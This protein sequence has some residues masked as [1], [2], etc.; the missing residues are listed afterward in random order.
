[1]NRLH[2]TL[3]ILHHFDSVIF[4]R[5]K[6]CKKYSQ[7]NMKDCVTKKMLERMNQDISIEEINSDIISEEISQEC[8]NIRVCLHSYTCLNI[9]D[10]FSFNEEYNDFFHHERFDNPELKARVNSVKEKNK[11]LRK[12]L[13]GIKY[14]KLEI[15]SL[16]IIC[17]I[18]R[19][20]ILC[21]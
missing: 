4:G 11:I 21:R 7:F 9:L 5:T 8:V 6:F 17:V 15:L 19:M 16:L 1:M 2:E 20:E 3:L 14:R 18:K 12:K 10:I 13:I